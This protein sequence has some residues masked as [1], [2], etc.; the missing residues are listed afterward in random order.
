MV[1]T[2]SRRRD[3]RRG[4]VAVMVAISVVVV[5]G[6]VAIA[7]DGGIM[8]A[9]RRHAQAVADATALAAAAS[10]FKYYNTENGSDPNNHAR[11][12]ALA[13]AAANGYS[14][15]GNTSAITPNS[16]SGGKPMHG[17]WVPPISGDHAGAAGYVEVAV[18][19]NQRRYFSAIFGSG[20]IPIRARAVA[21]G[22]LGSFDASILLLSKTANPSLNINGNAHIKDPGKII[23]DSTA[24]G[25]INVNGASG[26]I[27]A[28]EVDVVGGITGAVNQVNAPSSGSTTNV[29][30]NNASLYTPD[31]LGASGINLPAPPVPANTPWPGPGQLKTKQGDTL[32]PG[33]YIGGILVQ[34]SVQMA[35]GVYYIEGGSFDINTNN[36][37]VTSLP[38]GVLIYLTKD[39]SGN[40]AGFNLQGNATANLSP[41]ST[42]RYAGITI[43]QDRTAPLDNSLITIQGGSTSNLTG[44]VYAPQAHL[45]ISGGNIAA[46]DSYIANTLIFNGNNTLNMPKPVIPVR[47]TRNFGMVE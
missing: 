46:G 1:R 27:V 10:L 22:F 32:Q 18:Q 17:I 8:Q 47:A 28:G 14:N 35:S 3:A 20:T 36:G 9:E 42:G 5:L 45:L 30:T 38:G 43:F 19:Y 44:M 13:I 41:M 21:R 23:V 2:Q 7:V 26:S 34:K 4:A 12:S 37:S 29:F 16:A 25:A 39:S 33:I 15:D 40:Y 6:V 24:G 11:D 31:P